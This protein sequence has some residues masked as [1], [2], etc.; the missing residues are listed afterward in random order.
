M[1]RQSFSKATLTKEV[2]QLKRYRHFLPS[3]DLKRQQ[4]IFQRYKAAASLAKIEAQINE[5]RAIVLENLPMMS[6]LRI[7]LND[8]AVV[9]AVSIGKENSVGVNLPVLNAVDIT[10]KPY[11]VYAKPH[12]VDHAV[13]LLRRMLELKVQLSIEQRRFDILDAAVKKVTQRVN[14]FDKILIPRAEKTIKKIGIFL[15]DKERAA[16]VGAKITKQKR[17]NKGSSCP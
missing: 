1:P 2:A 8:L 9:S 15:A 10:L 5:C 13:I 12:W 11:S 17:L 6:D 3:L 14:F 16:I 4:L 7:V